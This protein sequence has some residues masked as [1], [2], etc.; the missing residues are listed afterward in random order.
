MSRPY[1]PNMF[2][3]EP[4]SG[5]I[6]LSGKLLFFPGISASIKKNFQ[7][8]FGDYRI[9]KHNDRRTIYNDNVEFIMFTSSKPHNCLSFDRYPKLHVALNP[10]N[11]NDTNSDIQTAFNA[12]LS[13]LK[14]YEIAQFK[15][16]H[17]DSIEKFLQQQQYG[18]IFT[19]YLGRRIV[20]EGLEIADA[21]EKAIQRAKFVSPLEP[22]EQRA[23]ES[24]R[25]DDK[26]VGCQFVTIAL[27]SIDP[28]TYQKYAEHARIQETQLSS[29]SSDDHNGITPSCTVP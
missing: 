20:E 18:K 8:T 5:M 9:T 3:C 10:E 29:L 27:R 16:I 2:N 23:T 12:I 13:V 4:E 26:I 21:I 7:I 1:S 24:R 15:V 19:I 14:K 22:S 25:R 11:Y 6:D 17:P 28:N